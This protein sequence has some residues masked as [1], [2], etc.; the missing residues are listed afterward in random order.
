[1]LNLD[2]RTVSG[3]RG[4]R[5]VGLTLVIVILVLVRLSGGS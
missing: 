4:L 1:M 5:F 3:W 2:A